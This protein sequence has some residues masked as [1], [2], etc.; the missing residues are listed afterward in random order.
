MHVLQS[1][2]PFR[3]LR[4]QNQAP[5][6]NA[7]VARDTAWLHYTHGA[8]VFGDWHVRYA[9]LYWQRARS[10]CG[11]SHKHFQNVHAKLGFPAFELG[12][13]K[14]ASTAQ[15]AGD[16]GDR[17]ALIGLFED[18]NDRFD[19]IAFLLHRQSPACSIVPEN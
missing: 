14:V 3:P 13:W 18:R 8:S 9:G 10:E 7:A 15:F 1:D 19:R 6:D 11:S 5:V 4:T 12:H 2:A 17:C 16:L